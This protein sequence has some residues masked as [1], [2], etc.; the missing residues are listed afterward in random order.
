MKNIMDKFFNYIGLE[1]ADDDENETVLDNGTEERK[2][3]SITE[4]KR[5]K[6]KK[7]VFATN[8]NSTPQRKSKIFDLPS[9]SGSSSKMQV[10]IFKPKYFEDIR[11][12][13]DELKADKPVIIN[14]MEI[15]DNSHGRMLDCLSGVLYAIEGELVKV[16]DFI[17]LASPSD[18]E[19]V[20]NI[21]VEAILGD[22]YNPLL[23]RR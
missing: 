18:V 19:A 7:S 11:M 15:S 4:T 21:S 5:D 14:F 17:Y 23:D 10:A 1:V 13:A 8:V 3:K 12:I 22:Q 20:G 9:I 16:S 2:V 6:N